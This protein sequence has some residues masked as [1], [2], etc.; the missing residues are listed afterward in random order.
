LAAGITNLFS[1]EY[2]IG[3]IKLELI[4]GKYTSTL[5]TKL[6]D[7]VKFRQILEREETGTHEAQSAS[8]VFRSLSTFSNDCAVPLSEFKSFHDT[9][10]GAMRFSKYREV[11][12]SRMPFSSKAATST[13]RL[14]GESV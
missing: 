9:R 8:R 5:S 14:Y 1:L 13:E 2:G 11:F 12:K 4:S 3:G 10:G 7:M 6:L